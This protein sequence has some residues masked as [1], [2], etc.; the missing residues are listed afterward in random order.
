MEPMLAESERRAGL[1]SR[2]DYTFFLLLRIGQGDLL[3][4][5]NT[6]GMCD[7]AQHIPFGDGLL[8]DGPRE[9]FGIPVWIV[10]RHKNGSVYIYFK[11][12]AESERWYAIVCDLTKKPVPKT[13]FNVYNLHPIHGWQMNKS[14]QYVK[15][16]RDNLVGYGTVVQKILKDIDVSIKYQSFLMNLGESHTLNYLLH[17]PPGVGKTT[18]IKTI[19]T[20]LKLPIFVVKGQD[21]LNPAFPID[22]ILNPVDSSDTGYRILIFEDFDRFLDQKESKFSM[23]DILNSMDGVVSSTPVI[24]FF[25]GNNCDVVFKNAALMSRMTQ[26]FPFT[27]PTLDQYV[28]KLDHFLSFYPSDT[29]DKEKLQRLYATM[30]VLTERQVSLRKFSAY[31]VRYM[32]DD[33]YL[34]ALT[35]NMHELM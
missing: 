35:K 33:D 6:L 31:V 8:H 24:R 30:Q 22:Y 28:C 2:K 11:S 18:L 1:R 14:K 26:V 17:G 32:F 3:E 16:S 19:A 21:L 7:G 15:T 12:K 27:H 29:L 34:D 23:A 9:M 5:L 10:D 25:T 13:T 4:R 20:E